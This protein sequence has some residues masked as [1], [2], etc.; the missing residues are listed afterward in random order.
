MMFFK[1]KKVLTYVVLLFILTFLESFCIK[2][3]DYKDKKL[4]FNEFTKVI[5]I[6][7]DELFFDFDNEKTNLSHIFAK[8]FLRIQISQPLITMQ[9]LT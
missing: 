3:S 4:D 9:C 6:L 8:V 2:L 1:C 5:S 7:K